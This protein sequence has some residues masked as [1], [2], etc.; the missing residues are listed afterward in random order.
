MCKTGIRQLDTQTTPLISLC[1]VHGEV[2]LDC[3]LRNEGAAHAGQCLPAG[4]HSRGIH[5]LQRD[6][7]CLFNQLAEH[8]KARQGE[9][10]KRR[11]RCMSGRREKDGGRKEREEE[12]EGRGKKEKKMKGS[13]DEIKR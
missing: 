7:S 5:L 11:K 1:D 6:P 4:E 8:L 3:P 13:G 2:A 12:N 9:M 10:V